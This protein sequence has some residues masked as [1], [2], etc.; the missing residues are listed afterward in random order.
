[1]REP[2]R[3]ARI[4][5]AGVLQSVIASGAPMKEWRVRSAYGLALLAHLASRL[6]KDA[7]SLPT[8]NLPK[9]K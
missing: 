9:E 1:M 7:T 4:S 6:D 5:T 2:S 8:P 3:D